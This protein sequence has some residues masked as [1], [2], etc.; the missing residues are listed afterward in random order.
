MEQRRG[1][2]IWRVAGAILLAC[3]CVAMS[4]GMP[5]GD[6]AA[7]RAVLGRYAEAVTTGDIELC[8]QLCW[9]G[10]PPAHATES[11]VPRAAQNVQP[12]STTSMATTTP[13][14]DLEVTQV[15]SEGDWALAAG[16]YTL[17]WR[18]SSPV[19]EE[20]LAMLSRKTEGWKIVEVRRGS[21]LEASLIYWYG[22]DH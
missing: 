5:A 3:G 11:T 4:A 14:L 2:R 15:W 12:V 6:E 16:V 1:Q 22:D 17:T 20:F 13:K 19:S 18:G 10:E 7:V 9:G 8:R 21:T